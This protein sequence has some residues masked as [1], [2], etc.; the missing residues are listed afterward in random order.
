MT[1][2]RLEAF[3]DGVIAIIITIM[4][5]SIPL[6]KSFDLG[7]LVEFGLSLFIYLLS[8]LVVGAFWNQH[9]QAFSYLDKMNHKIIAASI[10]FLFFLSLIP[11]FTKWVIENQGSLIPAIG[12]DI[13]YLTVS[14]FYVLTFRFIIEETDNEDIKQITETIKSR[15]TVKLHF[16]WIPI[17]ILLI[18][19]AILILISIYLPKVA[20]IILLGVPI[21]SSIFNLFMSEREKNNSR[22]GAKR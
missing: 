10:F 20:T 9:H 13:V 19:I 4:V 5:L 18:T 14:F 15:K 8:F 6:P 17:I 12:Y 16:S 2:Y 3:T 21:A 22:F 11:L 1:K 7:D